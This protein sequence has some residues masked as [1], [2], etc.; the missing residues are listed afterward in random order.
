MIQYSRI[1]SVMALVIIITVWM[2]VFII[3]SAPGS[4]DHLILPTQAVFP[5]T[6]Q[7]ARVG[8]VQPIVDSIASSRPSQE[9]G[10]T[11]ELVITFAPTSTQSE[12]SAYLIEIGATV[13]QTLDSVDTVIVT[14]PEDR[15]ELPTT[16]SPVI[17][18]SEPNY[19]VS[20][21]ELPA[22][23]D[24]YY[25]QQWALTAIRAPAAW[26]SL[27]DDIISIT[28]AVIDS[29]VTATH[30]DLAG[31]I[32][33][34]WDFVQ[35]DAQPQDDM[36][37][38]T[39]I[40]GIIA[41]NMGNGLGIAGV[42]PNA[43]I[44]PLRVLDANGVGTYADVAAA[45]IYATDHGAQVINLSL[46]GAF[47][48]TMLQNA[49]SYALN[50]SVIIIAAGGNT[51]SDNAVYP[52]AF[53][54]VIGVG[55]VDSDL[56][57]SSF[58]NYGES[59]DVLAP[60]R[61]IVTTTRDGGYALFTGTSMA[62]PHVA[63]IAA[64]ELGQGR[65]L[66]LN[67][68]II[69]A[70]VP[71]TEDTSVP[72]EDD[73]T[74]TAQACDYTL[75]AGDSA[76]LIAAVAASE[77]NTIAETICLTGGV[78]S[79]TTYQ[80]I[81]N[82]RRLGL[83][84][85]HG[86]LTVDGN[87]ATLRDDYASYYMYFFD[88]GPQGILTLNNVNL[89]HGGLYVA[90]E[91][92]I[93]TASHLD[94]VVDNHG[95]ATLDAVI[96]Q[97]AGGG[98]NRRA[99]ENSDVMIIRNSSF[100][101][102]YRIEGGAVRNNGNLFIYDTAFDNNVADDA[103]GAI[104]NYNGSIY[105]F[106]SIFTNN[107]VLETDYGYGA[108]IVADR[109]SVHITDSCFFGNTTP[110]VDGRSVQTYNSNATIDAANNWWGVI[111]G[112]SLYGLQ[113]VDSVSFWVTYEPYL[114]I[115]PAGCPAHPLL[116]Y[117]QN[118]IL[119]QD[120]PAA[121]TLQAWGGRPP[122][123]IDNVTTP[124]HGV[125]T[126]TIPDLT[127][128]PD[129]GYS[130]YDSFTFDVTDDDGLTVTATVT[131][132][133]GVTP[134][135]T[136]MVD[137]TV[138]ETP[139]VVN[140]N[141]TLGEAIEAANTNTAVDACNAG[142][143]FTI[144]YISLIPGT[145]TVTQAHVNV[146]NGTN[147]YPVIDSDIT[148]YGAGATVTRSGSTNFRFFEV[149]RGDFSASPGYQLTI[150]N[151][152]LENGIATA[153][154][155]GA[156]LAPE[157]SGSVPVII[158]NSAFVNNQA[159]NLSG[160]AVRGPAIVTDSTFT[161]NTA[162]Y[163]GALNGDMTI[164][165]STFDSNTAIT[166][167]GVAYGGA[168]YS[169]IYQIT[170][171]DFINNS[172]GF[173]G[174]IYTRDRDSISTLTDSIFTGNQAIRGGAIH[175]EGD[176]LD[177]TNNVFADQSASSNGGFISVARY[178]VGYD[179]DVTANNN[180]FA[181][182]STPLVYHDNYAN[183]NLNDNWWGRYDGISLED[184]GASVVFD[185]FYTTPPAING[186]IV[187]P[188]DLPDQT[189][190][191]L[192][193]TSADLT[194]VAE[195]GIPPYSFTD[196]STPANGTVTGTIPNLTYTPNIGFE[197]IDTFTV[198]VENVTGESRTATMTMNVVNTLVLYAGPYGVVFNQPNPL[199]LSID[200]GVPPYNVVVD[201]QP[202]NGV[203]T[204]T[205]PDLIYTPD[206]NFRD[207]DAVDLTVTD[208][209]GAQVTENVSL[210]IVTD[211]FVEDRFVVAT[212][213]TPLDITLIA[214]GGREPYVFSSISTPNAGTLTGTAPNLV[215]TPPAGEVDVDTSFTFDVTDADNWQAS[216]I[217]YVLVR[218]PLTV[219]DQYA[220]VT[221]GQPAN[222]ILTVDTGYPSYTFE[223]GD[224]THGAATIN[225]AQVTYTMDAFYNQVDSIP[226]TVTDGGGR[227]ADATLYISGSAPLTADYMAVFTSYET[228]IALNLPVMG[229]YPPYSYNVLTSPTDGT[230]SG[231]APYWT[232]T[233]D[234]GFAGADEIEYEVVDGQGFRLTGYI[235]II[236][237]QPV[238]FDDVEVYTNYERA[239]DITMTG[240]SG[241]FAP[242]SYEVTTP[243]ANGSLTGTFPNYEY[244]PDA[245]FS[246]TD[247]FVVTTSDAYGTTTTATVTIHVSTPIVVD[248]SDEAGLIAAIVAAEANG[249]PDT[250][251]LTTSSYDF[252]AVHNAG[253]SGPS[254]L[255]VISTEIVFVGNGATLNRDTTTVFR[256]IRMTNTA[257]VEIDG[258]EFL[259]GRIGGYY[260]AAIYNL[261]G[262][263]TITNSQFNN[264]TI[265]TNNYGGA[266]YSD[267]ITAIDNTD[268][269]GN[270]AYRGGA[271]YLRGT[272]TITN[273]TFD[274]NASTDEGGVYVYSGEAVIT[275][276]IFINNNATTIYASAAANPDAHV[277]VSDSCII[278][279]TH[280]NSD[281]AVLR[282]VGATLIVNDNWWGAADGPRN[283]SD[284]LGS[285]TFIGD[286][287]TVSTFLTAPP[288]GC[289]TLP[290]FS[291]ERTFTILMN[292]PIT[293][294]FEARGGTPPYTYNPD[295]LP[296]N[297]QLTTTAT[298][299][300][301][302]PDPGFV[303]TDTFYY[304][305]LDFYGMSGVG[306]IRIE[307][308]EPLQATNPTYDTTSETPVDIEL[309][310]TGG[311]P[312]ITH[313]LLT[314]PANGILTGNE[315]SD[316]VY[317]PVVGFTG[318][319]TIIYEVEDADST[320]VTV[321]IT[322]NVLS[323]PPANIFVDTTIQE[324]PLVN[325]GNCTLA[326]AILAATG[327][328]AVDNCA[329]GNV[330][331]V[332]I[333]DI[334]AGTYEFP[335]SY[336]GSA[337]ALPNP[338]D[339]AGL[340][341]RG[342]GMDDTILVSTGS[343]LNFTIP[344][345]GSILTIR[346]LTLQDGSTNSRGGAIRNAGTLQI[347]QVR[348]ANNGANID[349][350]AIY[351]T[352]WLRV[353]HSIFEHNSASFR[354]GAL[355]NNNTA[356][357]E[358][359]ASAFNDNGRW[360][361]DSGSM[362]GADLWTYGPST[363]QY[364]CLIEPN[365]G[366][367][368]YA[369]TSG[370]YVEAQ[371]NW[372]GESGTEVSVQRANTTPLL[373]TRPAVCDLLTP[374]P[375]PLV[376]N[377]AAG[378][379]DGLVAAIE[380][381]NLNGEAIIH[382]ADSSTYVTNGSY[383][384]IGTSTLPIIT[385][386]INIV[387]H[388]ATITR[389][390]GVTGRIFEVQGGDLTLGNVTI[391]DGL[392]EHVGGAIYTT[393]GTLTI[394]NG[395]FINN[396][397]GLPTSVGNG[398]A[399]A[400]HNTQVTITDSTF[401]N[402]AGDR[403]GALYLYNGTSEITGTVF[404]N[405]QAQN[406]GAIFVDNGHDLDVTGSCF[407]E[408]SDTGLFNYTPVTVEATN[409]WWGAYSG[410]SGN[411]TGQGDSISENVTYEPFV[412]SQPVLCPGTAVLE[413]YDQQYDMS[414]FD[415]DIA[416]EVEIFGGE[417]DFAF[418]ITASPSNGTLNGT[419]PSVT[420]TPDP[421]FVGMDSFTYEVTDNLAATAS[422]TVTITVHGATITVDSTAQEVPFV[423]NGNCTL[424]EAITAANTDTAV[425]AC[426]AGDG[427]DI[428]V[429][430]TD[431][432][433]IL[434]QVDNITSIGSTGLPQI[435]TVI[436]IQGNNAVIERSDAGGIPEFRIFHVGPLGDLT[437][438]TITV[439]NGAVDMADST[440]GRGGGIYARSYLHIID[441][442][443]T[444][445]SA[446]MGGGLYNSGILTIENSQVT[447]NTAIQA[448]GLELGGIVTVADTIITGNS[449]DYGGGIELYNTD[450]S[451]TIDNSIIA[452]NTA[453]I[454]GGGIEVVTVH[455][456]HSLT[457]SNSQILNNTA[458]IG[459]SVAAGRN[460]TNYS[461]NITISESCI[462]GA[463]DAAVN[464]ARP[465]NNLIVSDNWWGSE[466]G[467]G[468]DGGGYGTTLSGS[469]ATYTPFYT[470]PILGCDNFPVT[471]INVT[472]Y[473][474]YEQPV[475]VPTLQAIDGTPPYIFGTVAVP[476]N[477]M[478]T[479]T[480]PNSLVYTPN[481]GFSG[482]DSFTFEIMD[483]NSVVGYGTVTVHVAP[484]LVA[485]DMAII[486]PHE[487]AVNLTLTAAGGRTPYNV[488]IATSPAHGTITGTPPN[489]IYTPDAG[490][491][492]ADS[493]TFNVVD[494]NGALATG[495]VNITVLQHVTAI[496]RVV[497]TSKNVSLPILLTAQYGVP[498][499]EFSIA[500]QPTHGIVAQAPGS[501]YFTYI[502]H[503]DY[504]GA[505]SFTFLV[506]D[507]TGYI[508][509]G[510][511][512]ITVID[513]VI[514]HPPHTL[515]ASSVSLTQ[516]NLLWT[517]DSGDE[518][519]FEIERSTNGVNWTPLATVSP[520]VTTY[521][522]TGLT[523][524]TTYSYRVRAFRTSDGQF[525][526]YTA[527]A[528]VALL[529]IPDAP[530]NLTAQPTS[531]SEITLNWV[532][533]GG[534]NS[535]HIE[536]SVND[537]GWQEIASV[538]SATSTYVDSGLTCA[539]NYAYRMRS[540]RVD[541]SVYT[542][543]TPVVN[544]TIPCPPAA[545]TLLSVNALSETEIEVQWQD[546]SSSE[547]QYTI[548]YSPDGVD[549]WQVA[550][551]TAANQ[552]TYTH[553]GLT[554][555]TTLYYRVQAVGMFVTQVSPYTN[556][557]SAITLPCVPTNTQATANGMN[558]IDVTWQPVSV[559]AMNYQIEHSLNGA[560]NWVQ[561]AVV[562]SAVGQYNHTPL[563]CGSTH[564]Y[565]IR[566]LRTADGVL[567]PYTSVFSAT[568]NSCPPLVPPQNPT[569]TG[570]G[571]EE[572]RVQWEIPGGNADSYFI[573][574]SSDGTNWSVLQVVPG[575]QTTFVHQ[576]LLCDTFYFYRVRAYREE[577]S[578]FSAYTTPVSGST[579]ACPIPVE[580]TIGLY[581]NG[582]WQFRDANTDGP[583]EYVFTFGPTQAGWTPLIGDWDG[584]G[585]DGIGLYRE[586]VWL[587]RDATAAGTVDY[588]FIFGPREPG[589]QPVIGDWNGDD[590]DTIGLYRD[591][592]WL[593]RNSNSTG[594]FQ[595]AFTFRPT[596]QG[597]TP[598]AGDWNGSGVDGV[599]FYH[600]GMWMLHNT[601][602]NTD[603]VPTFAFGPT[604]GDWLPVVGDWNGD[605]T[606][607]IGV[608]RNGIWRLR[609]TSNAGAPDLGFTFGVQQS[610]WLPIASYRD[611]AGGLGLS[612]LSVAPPIELPG[613]TPVP[614]MPAPTETPLAV[615]PT[616][617]AP[618]VTPELEVTD[619]PVAVTATPTPTVTA[620]ETEP[621]ATA[622]P[623]TTA[624]PTDTPVPT[625][626]EPLLEAT[627]EP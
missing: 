266:I 505:D 236:V 117:D 134:A 35:D 108:A 225:G 562:D 408:N 566:A 542:S 482:V 191:L 490:Y 335:N 246:G 18:A 512:N 353:A 493:F 436:Y 123:V 517:D 378:D 527:P 347:I 53:A 471:G 82:S 195:G 99:I 69:A 429:L 1:Y 405:N 402:N 415:T 121:I 74:V 543:Y 160:G 401:I 603:R 128:T 365:N 20:A 513:N 416:I 469:T 545:P 258:I 348:F 166:S 315:P 250:I 455:E 508:H 100:S 322:I 362:L 111:Y 339:A 116:P 217:I 308:V 466:T 188:P 49:V 443:I 393:N 96:A 609:N 267:G 613:A 319:D 210:I 192:T 23:N 80:Q 480:S 271:L 10:E 312:P 136:I 215:Y 301:Y 547:T 102:F 154:G 586:G 198:A 327:N 374:D 259:N 125:L 385:G 224:P 199:Y 380:A 11:G 478:V 435:V 525:S 440:L 625:S 218:E 167:S 39:A 3:L 287:V 450:D 122:Y 173:G 439:Q 59:I 437:L 564:Y 472:L 491:V 175:F 19:Y 532:G 350:G 94:V 65:A 328:V 62:A 202:A 406:G 383:T 459:G 497:V 216:G 232:Y 407:V 4:G 143:P 272:T 180:C 441:S 238:V 585:V 456:D 70:N 366:L 186:C 511:I 103:G 434:T 461:A 381:G 537:G 548:E 204:G 584:D 284:T 359:Y 72:V 306:S 495:T 367:S 221:P 399:I 29:G 6:Q 619:E 392:P 354:G 282:E 529:C 457:I 114:T 615:D 285:G 544:A 142:N 617:E 477:G 50:R 465:E 592:Q 484:L 581:R 458:P 187:F 55:S 12:R 222:I 290:A 600:N 66:T 575:N 624:T 316:L 25:P 363:I 351:N 473:T 460:G 470:A 573:E 336:S 571:R 67:G 9:S 112:P 574:F 488:S 229:G 147:A 203:I 427:D 31:R 248:A 149:R 430:A 386:D 528:S 504:V 118:L 304:E 48:S 76:G 273:S 514:L 182:N 550:G 454:Q 349:G 341:L 373:G 98:T 337:Q 177:I 580:N 522:D 626:E 403:G 552:T 601:L 309:P 243:P 115:P 38:G 357:L 281:P 260:G 64:L 485:T 87:G 168:V 295:F 206:F 21:L 300:T 294:P 214:T 268:F 164:V 27:P 107:Q 171:S 606:D 331:A 500:S 252:T 428:I 404:H 320:T 501:G 276:S 244:M 205:W 22:A 602:T 342:A 313:T 468:G 438:D 84:Q 557:L 270:F 483:D 530:T 535:H 329:A 599:G 90:G 515:V 494:D 614:T 396:S 526:L 239:I 77:G 496:D 159:P 201:S 51:G 333:I 324:T 37:H 209:V 283:T 582:V 193:N 588:V 569:V 137:S 286:F 152:T 110:D 388:N 172:G 540:F 126:G 280:L 384:G 611:S 546:N 138:Q 144:D 539:T 317:I 235:L 370:P 425:D 242:Y 330:A 179:V 91:L 150:E 345:A 375:E 68:T 426:P 568:T 549:N 412:T 165:D 194:I 390:S 81:V 616:T 311:V 292:T 531:E 275:G 590:V 41:A 140:G 432:V 71:E 148:I 52:A 28:I 83:Q 487:R 492:G 277:T 133:I 567:S 352:G 298:D 591:G 43:T 158:V 340:I 60:G 184:I 358:V 228:P 521:Q 382:L 598:I 185:T 54:G 556:S 502:P 622:E 607:T 211:L 510:T 269:F 310:Y 146:S 97:G 42:A 169:S 364:S 442:V 448:G 15:A 334:P 240:A 520:D 321:T 88:V 462:M 561:L 120:V 129:G 417:P 536:R 555:N 446:Y 572:I 444:G 368:I 499:Y 234:G 13:V 332:D 139:F 371:F 256:F 170:G 145:Y 398:G 161:G 247:T 254:A 475:A 113:S 278:S 356:T 411:G 162:R 559:P 608:Y 24:T 196:I 594:N 190:D 409:N 279:N 101:G 361:F 79:L 551:T 418:E 227:T 219:S 262:Q 467:P 127:Y 422:A 119:E 109:G 200:G 56:S 506:E 618:E 541:E 245:S 421:G 14:L 612:I 431:T 141:C 296:S 360:P 479:G 85:I 151:L 293:I 8:D 189:I 61:D 489:I 212:Y 326:E 233:P 307:V 263:L 40:A 576:G 305:I 553:N 627:A 178:S 565:R 255:P 75:A 570:N 303:G 78:Y 445:N 176:T 174:A 604:A 130:G 57:R 519:G 389:D 377:I 157:N 610:G 104:Y 251:I 447:N 323:Q 106:R 394:I 95:D 597:W 92:T 318:V 47:P 16:S 343:S 579:A 155:G 213:D 249:I 220:Y 413:A 124:S 523:C 230:L 509:T 481:A 288:P 261:G 163:G 420:Y 376:F 58:S 449:A 63:G 291:E 587:L 44:M 32:T 302:T 265:T 476:G 237:G 73:D 451:V 524:D 7:Q 578:A 516:I 257:V 534:V 486:V 131:L 419:L 105:I 577:D 605:G 153:I 2:G 34:G 156:I 289:P 533:Q 414:Q 620:T 26:N 593:L 297:G 424:G 231:A 583:A 507:D 208:S 621:T 595:T 395:T 33:A 463:G 379:V 36:G 474:E 299:M 181:N 558:S 89:E 132:N 223:V 589:W 623:M 453:S 264:N 433:Y 338:M 369:E 563:I 5:D 46:G 410:P 30:V 538:P 45:I 241:G 554:C 314:P 226:F 423:D 93:N 391:S 344:T 253:S 346:D 518:S 372:W 400:T 464:L 274:N 560:T 498:P 452:D 86:E 596:G 135:A 397:T 183:V 207:T 387:G 355:W 17:V 197:G 325:N 503:G